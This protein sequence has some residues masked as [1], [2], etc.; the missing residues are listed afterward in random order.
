MNKQILPVGNIIV[1]REIAEM[2]FKCDLLKCKGACC[3]FESKY[4]APVTW[5]EIDRISNILSTVIDYVPMIHRSVIEEDGFYDII[6]DEPLLKSVDHRACVFVYYDDGIAKCSIEK[7]FLEGKTDFKKPISCH[8]FP[9][10]ISDFGGD[11]L[12]YEHLNECQPAIELGKKENTTVAEFCEEPL[13][14]LYGE[15]WYSQFKELIGK[16]NANT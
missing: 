16:Q 15:E 6:N 5:E 8:L 14:R 11:V 2:P 10:R 13:N 7:A 12:R 3:T 4:G 9:I 1:K